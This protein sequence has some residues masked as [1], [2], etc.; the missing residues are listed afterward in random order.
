MLLL[1]GKEAARSK[2]VRSRTEMTQMTKNE[3]I[4]HLGK[5]KI[6]F[7][8]VQNK[9]LNGY[10]PKIIGSFSFL[11]NHHIG[12]RT[13]FK[14]YRTY[15]KCEAGNNGK[16]I[17]C[18]VLNGNLDVSIGKNAVVENKGNFY[19]GVKNYC[20][21][22]TVAGSLNLGKNS[23]LIIEG[24]VIAGPGVRLEV[25]E[26]AVLELEDVYINS[27]TRIE[28]CKHVKIGKG[29]IIGWDVV[30]LDSDL[31]RIVR[32]DFEMNKPILIGSHVWIGNRAMILKGVT[33]G[34][35]SIVACG[36]IVTRNVPE[37]TLVGGVPAK[38]IK[39]D[40]H[41]EA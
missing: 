14:S 36:A 8:S 29:T 9:S 35:G 15:L 20:E 2:Q 7:E 26:Q 17:K 1:R 19:F 22:S 41:W 3:L 16:G 24:R 37:N 31:H 4:S 21:P 18:F 25:E 40:I 10:L 39:R 34:S 12:P 33:I 5:T 23:K 13:L 28:C 11:T 27:N 38:V 30:I 6:D 32:K